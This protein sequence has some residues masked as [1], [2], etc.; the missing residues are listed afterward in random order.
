MDAKRIRLSENIS[1][2]QMNQFAQYHSNLEYKIWQ[3]MTM[4]EACD[5]NYINTLLE[6]TR[7]IIAIQ[8]RDQINEQH[9][10]LEN[11]AINVAIFSYGLKKSSYSDEDDDDVENQQ[12]PTTSNNNSPSTS[13]SDGSSSSSLEDFAIN[14]AIKSFGLQKSKKDDGT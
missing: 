13:S 9:N 10:R 12:L 7:E 5:D 11:E 3:N 4:A 1:F 14:S 8:Q 2:P 6:N